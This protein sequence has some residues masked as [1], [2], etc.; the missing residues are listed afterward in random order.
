MSDEWVDAYDAREIGDE[1]VVAFEH[2]GR[3]YAL[4]NLEGHYYA[5]DGYCTHEKAHLSD[6]FVMDGMI[7]CPLHMG[8]FDIITGEAVAGP[9]CIHLKTYAVKE[10]NDRIFIKVTR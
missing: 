7:E 6:G 10:E 9:V 2:E 8:Q 3:T 1:E 5:T 4:Y